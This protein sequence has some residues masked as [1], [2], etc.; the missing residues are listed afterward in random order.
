MA[1]AQQWN[2]F[3]IRQGGSF[4][5]SFEWGAF[6][7]KV[8]HRVFR[9]AVPEENPAIAGQIIAHALPLGFRYFYV[10]RGP[11]GDRHLLGDWL[12]AIK[13]VADERKPLFIRI[14]PPSTSY[15]LP[16]TFINI[17]RVIQPHQNLILDLTKSEEELLGAMHEK[18]RYNMRLAVKHGVAI[19][20]EGDSDTFLKL[21]KETA[22]Q[23]Q[24]RLYPDTY[25]RTMLELFLSESQQVVPRGVLFIASHGGTSL[26]AA[27]C[28]GFGRRL[29]YLHGGSSREQREVMAPHMLHWHIARW[30]KAEGFSEYDMGGI[31]E[32]RWPGLT[33][34][35]TGF[36]GRIEE[37]PNAFELPF[38]KLPYMA[39]RFTRRIVR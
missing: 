33:R 11:V 28:V 19:S 36:G 30:A 14:E 34:F 21:L 13:K 17:G 35:K 7:E 27:F 38:K 20:E 22:T 32:K 12:S 29:T 18:T 25:F 31:D 37:F 26:A 24:F 6:Q 2:E 15:Q 8:G 3:M 23:Q 9:L 16:S 10:P 4:L 1:D 39:Y 5:Q